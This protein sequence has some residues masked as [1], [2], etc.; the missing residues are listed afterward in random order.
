MAKNNNSSKEIPSKSATILKNLIMLRYFL[1][2]FYFCHAKL[3]NQIDYFS[4]T[5]LLLLQ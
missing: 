1:I 4:K 2:S 3:A 5:N